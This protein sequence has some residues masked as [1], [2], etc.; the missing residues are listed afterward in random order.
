MSNPLIF[1]RCSGIDAV[2]LPVNSL[3]KLAF[4]RDRPW[5]ILSMKDYDS[6][7]TPFPLKFVNHFE[8]PNF[9]LITPEDMVQIALNTENL[10][11]DEEEA[12]AWFKAQEEEKNAA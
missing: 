10:K 6:Y 5:R 8:S 4:Y 9:Q 7:K 3:E 2:S 11:A 12:A 1:L